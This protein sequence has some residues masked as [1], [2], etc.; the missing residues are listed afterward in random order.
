MFNE[1]SNAPILIFHASCGFFSP[2]AESNATRLYIVSIPSLFTNF[3]SV[4]I[5]IGAVGGMAPGKK[6]ILS[7]YG[8]KAML[9]ASLV[10]LMSAAMVG[11]FV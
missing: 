11:M 1:L 7:E 6:H 9:A 2:V 8:L 3:A 4:G 10:A 5:L